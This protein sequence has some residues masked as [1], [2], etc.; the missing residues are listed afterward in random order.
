MHRMVDSLRRT[1]AL[2]LVLLLGL[3]GPAQAGSL[4]DLVPG[5]PQ[6]EEQETQPAELPEEGA[7][8]VPAETATE[9]ETEAETKT[10]TEA[11]AE[12]AAGARAASLWEAEV[13]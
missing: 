8:E 3:T 5:A 7:A 10:E 2:G 12:P 4:L 1:A 9:A 6:Q 13:G 11:E